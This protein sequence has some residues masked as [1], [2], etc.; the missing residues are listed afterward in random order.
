M[1]TSFMAAP[2]LLLTSE[3]VTEGHP[4]K[5]CDQ[6]SDAILDAM[7]KQD[8]QSRVACET[9]TTTGTIWVF[10]EVST[11]AYVDIESIVRGVVRR[12]G[13]TGSEMGF[14]AET[15][16]VLTSINDQSPDIAQGVNQALEARETAGE[17]DPYDLAGAGDQGMMIGFASARADAGPDGAAP[18]RHA[19]LP[20]PGRQITGHHRVRLRRAEAHRHGGRLHAAHT[21]GR[22]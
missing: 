13:Y 21:R 19:R 11:E 9:A 12:I 3:S 15:C 6:V 4:D 22:A 18:R 2:S 5:L 8:P 14:D 20:A 7:L 17:A 10:G 16:G 1:T